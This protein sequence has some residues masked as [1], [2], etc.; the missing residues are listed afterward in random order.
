MEKITLTDALAGCL[1]HCGWCVHHCPEADKYG[2]LV[3]C[4]KLQ[5]EFNKLYLSVYSLLSNRSTETIKIISILFNKIALNYQRRENEQ[6]KNLR[7][8]ELSADDFEKLPGC[9]QI[10]Q[11]SQ[12]LN[13]TYLNNLY[14]IE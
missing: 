13:E 2:I 12:I 10:F 5:S 7:M 11:I 4:L 1:D 3:T 9:S 8:K 6:I 14:G